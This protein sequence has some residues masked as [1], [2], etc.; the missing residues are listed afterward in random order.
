MPSIDILKNE[1]LELSK[2]LIN[3]IN[4]TKT[5]ESLILKNY[6]I[7]M[8]HPVTTEYLDSKDK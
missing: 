8:Q 7:L 6:V 5:N 2:K 3:K 1:K 4:S